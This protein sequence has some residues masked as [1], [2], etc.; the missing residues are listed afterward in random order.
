MRA[1]AVFA[2]L[3]LLGG[4][5]STVGS[6]GLSDEPLLPAPAEKLAEAPELAIA[7]AE[8]MLDAGQYV[9]A[10]AKFQSVLK[11]EPENFEARLGAA[12]AAL[13]VGDLAEALA[14]FES[15]MEAPAYRA[16]GLQGRGISLSLIGQND[17]GQELLLQA[18]AQDPELWR[19]W[20][21]IGRNRD[22]AN[23][24]SSAMEA[25]SMALRANP[26]AV[27]VHNNL[28]L[29]LMMQGRH[30]EAERAFRTALRIDPALEPA[31][32]NLRLAVARQGRYAEALAGVT[33]TQ[34]PAVMNN[35]GFVAMQRGDFDVAKAYFV[36]AMES[37]PSF[38]PKAA[39]NLEY[40]E[41]LKKTALLPAAAQG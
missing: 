3:L 34:L 16:K 31:R 33:P 8:A 28:G 7:R 20:N 15:V 19:A 38:Y 24:P 35:V 21:A 37:S 10:G 2:G 14:G 13:G 4:C 18:V 32:M 30:E 11:K 1:F 39:E 29:A 12:E 36:R 23:Q 5:T 6:S 41:E 27:A 9:Q 25:Y 26:A 22:L 40:L 17:L